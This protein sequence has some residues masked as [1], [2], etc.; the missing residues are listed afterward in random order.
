MLHNNS[1]SLVFPATASVGQHGITVQNDAGTP[2]N[3]D[4]FVFANRGT[5]Q[6]TYTSSLLTSN[7]NGYLR[8]QTPTGTTE[9][10]VLDFGLAASGQLAQK[11]RINLSNNN[12]WETY[13][14]QFAPLA[15]KANAKIRMFANSGGGYGFDGQQ[16]EHLLIKQID[17]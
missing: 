12:Q 2:G 5:Y 16:Y 4:V 10:D 6:I 11:W 8:L 17:K 14:F 7:A 3:G 13:S 9:T 15:L 1:Y